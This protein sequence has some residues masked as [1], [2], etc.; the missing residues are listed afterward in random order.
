MRADVGWLKCFSEAGESLREKYLSLDPGLS[1]DDTINTVYG[2]GPFLIAYAV[3]DP[4]HR[5]VVSI[6][7][8]APAKKRANRRLPDAVP[9]Q[10]C[11][12]LQHLHNVEGAWLYDRV[13]QA[14]GIAACGLVQATSSTR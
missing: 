11:F 12:C 3:A 5:V 2:R 10:W 1:M 14:G 7:V 13:D 4:G 8:S 6:E 9:R